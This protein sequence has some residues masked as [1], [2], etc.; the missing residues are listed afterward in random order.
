MRWFFWYF[1]E[2]KQIIRGGTVDVCVCKQAHSCLYN[3]PTKNLL[4]FIGAALRPAFVTFISKGNWYLKNKLCERQE[5]SVL[6]TA[7]LE[8]ITRAMCLI[9]W[10]H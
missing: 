10:L 4:F 7:M 1:E 3:M 6:F 2:Q 8:A 5:T 9:F